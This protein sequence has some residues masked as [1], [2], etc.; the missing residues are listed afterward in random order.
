MHQQSNPLVR[1]GSWSIEAPM[2]T[3]ASMIRTIA[4]N[5]RSLD[6]NSTYAYLLCCSIF[7]RTTRVLRKQ[8]IIG[9]FAT[10]LLKPDTPDEL[11]IWQVAVAELAQGKGLGLAMILDI[12]RGEVSRGVRFVEATVTPSNER[13]FRMFQKVATELRCP[14]NRT[15]GFK[16]ELF[17]TESHPPEE[18]IRIGPVDINSITP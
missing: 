5:S 1:K 11:F 6:V 16:S 9:G 18:C 2:E 15:A 12:I 7:K 17:E 13:S 3:D 10:G 14:L 4:Q 8:T